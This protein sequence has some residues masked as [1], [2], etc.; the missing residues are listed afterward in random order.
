ML[1]EELPE[2]VEDEPAETVPGPAEVA[3]QAEDGQQ[4]QQQQQQRVEP[5]EDDSILKNP[6]FWTGVGAGVLIAAVAGTLVAIA[7]L[8]EEAQGIPGNIDPPV[9]ELGR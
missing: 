6:W 2:P 5:R 7:V 3:Q 8:D 4:R 1:R 9:V